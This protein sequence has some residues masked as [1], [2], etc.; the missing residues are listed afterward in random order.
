MSRRLPLFPL[1]VV[2]FPGARAPLHIFEPRYQELLADVLEGD[3]T[4]GLVPT[5]DTGERAEP[6]VIG[7]VAEIVAHQPIPDGRAN[8]LVAGGRRFILRRWL[9][10]GT[11]YPL[12]LVDEFDDEEGAPDLAGDSL[13]AL[14]RLAD[15]CRTAMEALTDQAS[16]EPWSRDPGVLTFQVAGILPWAGDAPRRLLGYRSPAERAAVLLELLPRIVPDLE[17]RAAVHRHAPTNGKGR[18]PPDL[19]EGSPA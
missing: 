5:G 14:R 10:E 17:A 6:G 16:A 18:H 11:A 7:C 3:R 4:F 2:L 8:I 12:G 15:R 1:D 13:E 19:G 9:D